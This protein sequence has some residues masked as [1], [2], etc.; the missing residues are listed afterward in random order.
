MDLVST[1]KHRR[2]ALPLFGLFHIWL[3]IACATP[4]PY[5]AIPAPVNK[6]SGET[7]L[8]EVLNSIRLEERLPGLAAA[9]I[10]DGRIYSSAAVGVRKTGTKNWLTVN[11][12]FLL[13]SCE[14][15]FTATTAAIL[16]DEGQVG[17]QTTCYNEKPGH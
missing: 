9:I 1:N 7:E 11:D 12:K 13:G 17:W 14:K 10:G 15:A 6:D 4:P 2:L 8:A 5:K 3:V 16:V